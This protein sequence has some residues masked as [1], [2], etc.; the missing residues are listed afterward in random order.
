[1]PGR[2]K[3]LDTDGRVSVKF[4]PEVKR[5]LERV[6]DLLG[7]TVSALIKTLVEHGMLLEGV[8]SSGGEII[9]RAPNGVTYKLVRAQERKLLLQDSTGEVTWTPKVSK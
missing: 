5:S 2:S 8:M 9:A 4:S 3:E 7:I 6:A 1:M